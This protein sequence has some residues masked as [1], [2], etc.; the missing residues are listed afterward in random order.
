MY[1]NGPV[2][3]L[4]EPT[5]ALDPIAESKLYE[6]YNNMTREKTAVFISHR[7][8]STKFCDRILLLENGRIAEE[9]SHDVLMAQNGLYR[10]LFEIQSHYYKEGEVAENEA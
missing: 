7:L 8:A 3:I 6:E 10:E 1:R 9:G 2:L 5:S 4:D